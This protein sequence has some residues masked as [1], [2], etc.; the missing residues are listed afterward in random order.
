MVRLHTSK[1][2]KIIRW[3]VPKY[4]GFRVYWN[5]T[6]L[7]TTTGTLIHTPNWFKSQLP[8]TTF[9]AEL[10]YLFVST[11]QLP[12]SSHPSLQRVNS[13]PTLS[14]EHWKYIKLLALDS[15][16]LLAL[17]YEERI[18]HLRDHI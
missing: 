7:T 10:W 15:P 17:G 5:G 13:I 8:S 2:S 11:C 12:R 9:E 16:L 6:V 18:N 1:K 3:M 14:E 4:N